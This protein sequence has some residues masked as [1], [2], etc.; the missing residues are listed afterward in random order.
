MQD[1]ICTQ[2][3]YLYPASKSIA[4]LIQEFKMVGVCQLNHTYKKLFPLYV[5]YNYS[6]RTHTRARAHKHTHV[7]AHARTHAHTHTHTNLGALPMCSPELTVQTGYTNRISLTQNMQYNQ[8]SQD[9]M[10][11]HRL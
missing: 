7:R 8:P 6:T 11:P 1:C 2:T 3:I 10:L 5:F 4:W 9:V